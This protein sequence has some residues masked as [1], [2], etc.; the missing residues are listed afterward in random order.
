MNY[1]REQKRMLQR[2]GS[3]TSDGAAVRTERRTTVDR[4]REP[5]TK[6][7]EFVREVKAEMRKVAWPTRAEVRKYSIVVLI[8]IVVLT[9]MIAG[10][11]WVFGTLILKLFER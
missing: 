11:D 6:P 5:R 2:Q 8:A 9:A 10:L 1:N 3:L 4:S 7:V